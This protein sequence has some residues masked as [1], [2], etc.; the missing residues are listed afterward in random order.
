LK[1]HHDIALGNVLGSNI[2]NLLSVMALPAFFGNLAVEESAFNRD[3]LT[4]A[5]ITFILIAMMF[6]GV[7]FH[8]KKPT[9]AR[10]SSIFMLGP[11]LAYF[12]ILF[13]SQVA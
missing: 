3:F 4:M 1:G 13:N 8:Q 2:F 9:L 7:K 5:A 6:I 11:Y 12:I 10:W